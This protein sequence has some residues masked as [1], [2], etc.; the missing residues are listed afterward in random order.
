MQMKTRLIA[1][2]KVARQVWIF[3]QYSLKMATKL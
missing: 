3:G 2:Q 1:H